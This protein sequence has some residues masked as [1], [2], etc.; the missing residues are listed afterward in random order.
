MLYEVITNNLLQDIRLNLNFQAENF[1]FMNTTSL[2][3]DLFYGTVFGSGNIK[4]SGPVE[5]IRIDINATSEKN[6]Y[7]YLPLYTASEVQQ[8]DFITFILV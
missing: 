8:N 1:N 3:N 6:T 2:D 4:F 7:F 5:K